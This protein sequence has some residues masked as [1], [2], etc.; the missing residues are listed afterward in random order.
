MK[1]IAL[2]VYLRQLEVAV[3]S[4][5]AFALFVMSFIPSIYND[6]KYKLGL[7]VLFGFTAF[8]AARFLAVSITNARRGRK[9]STFVVTPSLWRMDLVLPRPPLRSRA[10]TPTDALAS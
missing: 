1:D 10:A 9:T 5:L 4:G 6:F 2:A 3:I 8:V 7:Q